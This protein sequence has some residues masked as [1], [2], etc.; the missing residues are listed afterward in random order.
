MGK[1]LL[2]KAPSYAPSDTSQPLADNLTCTSLYTYVHVLGI[3]HALIRT[4][5]KLRIKGSWTYYSVHVC[6]RCYPR[7]A[8]QKDVQVCKS[9]YLSNSSI[10]ENSNILYFRDGQAISN[11]GQRSYKTPNQACR[12]V[13]ITQ[14]MMFCCSRAKP[15]VCELGI[16][17]VWTVL[18]LDFVVVDI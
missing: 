14:T 13:Q 3:G 6:D 18:L 15:F 7:D 8:Y 10:R 9:P 12:M 17:A 5:A 2:L 11:N 4:Y 1:M 16:V